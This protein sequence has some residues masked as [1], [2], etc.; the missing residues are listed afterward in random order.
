MS[1]TTYKL[2]VAYDGT[3]YSG[4]QIQPNGPSIQALI[5]EA[6]QKIFQEKI[7]IIG[8]GR[9][10]AGVHALAQVAHFHTEKICQTS[11]V[12]F[13]LNCLLPKNIRILS[14]EK[15]ENPFHA[16]HHAKSKIYRYHLYLDKVLSPFKRPYVWH[17]PSSL[18]LDRLIVA[19]CHFLGTHDFT[20]F[21]N[22]ATRGVASYDPVRT[23]YR[24]DLVQEVGGLALEFEGDGFLYKMVRNMVGMLVDVASGK[25]E[26]LDIPKILA[27]KDRRLAS[28]AAP[29]L[30]LFL[31]Q[32]KY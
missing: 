18:D 22:E 3:N 12:S 8:S 19:S 10:D 6:L 30:G 2:I 4:W 7:R 1:R 21:S 15:T 32:V 14:L 20:S 17:V 28:Q 31:V 23:L 9:T 26:P 16:Q 29:A 24:I 25:K 5:E 11:R 13:S 27:A